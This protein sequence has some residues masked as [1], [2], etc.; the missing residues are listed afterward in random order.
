MYMPCTWS[1]QGGGELGGYRIRLFFAR[2]DYCVIE[3][4]RPD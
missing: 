1:V 4:S 2:F 3:G